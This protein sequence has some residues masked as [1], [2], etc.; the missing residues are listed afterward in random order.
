MCQVWGRGIRGYVSGMK[1]GNK[2]YVSGMGE[3]NK[4]ICV[5]YEGGKEPL[6]FWQ[7][8]LKGKK[9]LF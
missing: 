4:G 8:N 1:E 7:V 6:R 2:G 3:G 5:R 9:N